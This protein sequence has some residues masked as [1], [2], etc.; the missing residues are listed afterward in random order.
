MSIW[1]TERCCTKIRCVSGSA[2]KADA[3]NCPIKAVPDGTLIPDFRVRGIK[4]AL[5]ATWKNAKRGCCWVFR[6]NVFW[7]ASFVCL[8]HSSQPASTGKPRHK[9]KLHFLPLEVVKRTSH[10]RRTGALQFSTL[11]CYVIGP[12]LLKNDI[13]ICNVRMTKALFNGHHTFTPI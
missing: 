2:W 8:A 4:S 9:Y 13:R 7:Q 12:V 3:Q 1:D 11:K 10:E 6:G 5:T